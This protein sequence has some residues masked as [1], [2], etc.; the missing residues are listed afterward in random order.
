MVG[1]K[2]PTVVHADGAAARVR[3]QAV[4]H[5]RWRRRRVRTQV[6]TARVWWCAGGRVRWCAGRRGR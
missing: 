1:K 5:V 2:A 3:T 4:M 6:V